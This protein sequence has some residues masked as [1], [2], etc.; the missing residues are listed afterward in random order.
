MKLSTKIFSGVA[1][2][3]L[4][5]AL[6]NQGIENWGNHMDAHSS[7]DYV[8]EF[9]AGVVLKEEYPTVEQGARM[10]RF[11][12][13][14][15]VLPFNK[16]NVSENTCSANERANAAAPSSPGKSKSGPGDLGPVGGS[17]PRFFN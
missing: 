1:G 14:L 16:Y 2:V 9:M 4:L 8:P 5:G 17:M 7:P 3:A 15:V 11:S 10:N 12:S 13:C 6:V